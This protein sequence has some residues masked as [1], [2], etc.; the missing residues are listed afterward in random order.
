M[1]N[2]NY[3]L[4]SSFP[5][6]PLAMPWYHSLLPYLLYLSR[7]SNPFKGDT[8]S[9]CDLY[10]KGFGQKNIYKVINTLYW[11]K[12]ICTSK[13]DLLSIMPT[14]QIENDLYGKYQFKG[15]IEKEDTT[16]YQTLERIWMVQCCRLF[17]GVRRFAVATR[18]RKCMGFVTL[19]R[20]DI[21]GER[22]ERQEKW[23]LCFPRS[24]RFF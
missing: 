7:V 20:D 11:Q 19:L 23:C 4:V 15:N 18:L 24:R 14:N 2:P 6:Y 3:Y 8:S 10:H 1:S 17:P 5:K 12:K 21:F 22:E 13:N 9:D 16:D